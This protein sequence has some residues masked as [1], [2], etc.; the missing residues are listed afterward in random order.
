MARTQSCGGLLRQP[1]IWPGRQP[2]ESFA[3]SGVTANRLDGQ[4]AQ[5]AIQF[6]LGQFGPA[7]LPDIE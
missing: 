5:C 1:V 3:M 4:R 6:P 7:E 2:P